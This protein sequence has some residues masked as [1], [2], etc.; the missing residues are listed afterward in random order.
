MTLVK[1][2][3]PWVLKFTLTGLAIWYLLKKVDVGAAWEA[4]RDVASWA[5]VAA[6]LLQVVQVAIC[7]VRWQMVLRAI[8]SHLPYRQAVALFSMGIF[9]G[10]V[11]PGAVGGDAV[12]IWQTCRAGLSLTA[13]FNSVTL[14]RIATVFGLVLL[15]VMTQPLLASRLGDG[16]TLWVFPALT[17]ASLAGIGVLM[18]LDRMPEALRRWRIVRGFANLAG[19]T[20]RL[21]WRRRPAFSVLVVVI[22]GHINLALVVWCLALGLDAP[23]SLLDCLVLVPPVVLISTLPISIA[24]W[25]AREVAM[26]TLF[27]LVGVNAAQ[28]TAMSVL[29]GLASMVIALPGGGF[30]LLSTDRA[31]R[32]LEP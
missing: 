29:F 12:R 15:V 11:L 7:A 5:L 14:E 24:G 26:V 25:G 28:A 18:Q 19:D 22:V 13:A 30:W 8:G 16:A 1:R 20:R 4:G 6:V 10:Q 31:V 27:G 21:F 23:A 32:Q 2:L 17:V 9:F 3:A